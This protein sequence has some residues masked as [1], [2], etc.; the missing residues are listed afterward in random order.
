MGNAAESADHF[1]YWYVVGVSADGARR[2]RIRSRDSWFT[3][4]HTKDFIGRMKRMGR[5][6]P[7]RNGNVAVGSQSRSA[8][9]TS[10]RSLA[11]ASTTP[12]VRLFSAK[13][14]R[15]SNADSLS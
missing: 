1:L 6:G 9:R 11:T 7:R 2:Y 14:Q 10:S 12:R 13:N 5:T 4:R 8:E 3:A 15:P